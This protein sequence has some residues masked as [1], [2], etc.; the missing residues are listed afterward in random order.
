MSR[1]K[2]WTDWESKASQL[3]CGYSLY[4]PLVDIQV[5]LFSNDFEP[6]VF[7]FMMIELMAML[8]QTG[9]RPLQ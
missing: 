4:P 9:P 6:S 8:L 2:C 3:R 7:I 5:L 1:A